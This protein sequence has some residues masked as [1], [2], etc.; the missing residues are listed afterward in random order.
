MGHLTVKRR[1]GSR[2]QPQGK[3]GKPRASSNRVT[4]RKSA[5]QST[6]HDEIQTME[7]AL[8]QEDVDF[9]S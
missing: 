9:E 7:A 8:G 2:R 5:R 4:Y 6:M 3:G 1:R